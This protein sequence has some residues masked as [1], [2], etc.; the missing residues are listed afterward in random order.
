MS[1]LIP[2][3]VLL[4]ILQHK[5]NNVTDE[6][7][8]SAVN[9]YLTDNPVQAYDDSE[10]KSEIGELK[11]DLGN[12]R[13]ATDNDVGKVL[14]AKTVTD[15]KVTEWEFGDA[16]ETGLEEF[17]E[18]IDTTLTE[19][20]DFI[21][22]F[23]NRYKKLAGYII[24]GENIYTSPM[25]IAPHIF[26]IHGKPEK[27]NAI[28]SKLRNYVKPTSSYSNILFSYEISNKIVQGLY[29]VTN[30]KILLSP[31]PI[32]TNILLAMEKQVK[33]YDLSKGFSG[34]ACQVHAGDRIIVYGVRA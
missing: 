32:Q 21:A 4:A 1:D 11:S 24:Q 28:S 30:A 2:S 20:A 23:E 29:G 10:I 34:F 26:D 15:G 18:L 25:Y 5:T 22:S 7:V 6:Q 33:D 17:E 16:A 9:K 27:S 8:D 19:D 12:I 14:M 13:T 3:P 31:T